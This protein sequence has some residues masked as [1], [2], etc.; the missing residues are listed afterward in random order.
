M[1]INIIYNMWL[2][3]GN[4]GNRYLSF[5]SEKFI[6][7]GYYND[8]DD[9]SERN[10]TIAS[11]ENINDLHILD[12]CHAQRLKTKHDIKNDMHAYYSAIS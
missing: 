9:D 4:E 2:K 10:V 6:S 3:T 7:S 8:R 5:H 1:F 11:N 12:W